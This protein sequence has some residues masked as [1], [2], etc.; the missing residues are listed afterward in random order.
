[1][2]ED[3]PTPRPVMK[4]PAAIMGKVWAT[5]MRIAPATS[6]KLLMMRPFLEGALQHRASLN[7]VGYPKGSRAGVAHMMQT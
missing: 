5:A 7:R 3:R 2:Q 4:R 1:M 6:G